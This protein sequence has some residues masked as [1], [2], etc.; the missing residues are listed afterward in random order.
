MN[1]M[2]KVGVLMLLVALVAPQY[3]AGGTFVPTPV[4][5]NPTTQ[6]SH[7]A[8]VTLRLSTATARP[9]ESL[10]LFADYTALGLITTSLIVSP[11]D[12]VRFTPAVPSPCHDQTHDEEC[13]VFPLQA[14]ITG[15]VS[16][17]AVTHGETF[18]ADCQCW[19]FVTVS[20]PVVTLDISGPPNF[21]PPPRA[22]L[23]ML[24]QESSMAPL[25]GWMVF[26]SSRDA[27]YEIHSMRADG[28]SIQR[29]TSNDVHD[30]GADISPDG[31]TIVFQSRRESHNSLYLMNR[32]GTNQRRISPAGGWD[33]DP[34]WSPDGR[35]IAFT[36]YRNGN[37]EI[38]VMQADGSDARRL[39]ITPTNATYDSAPS[40]SPDGQTIAF[41]S[42]RHGGTQPSIYVMAADGTNL[43]RLTEG[44][45][46]YPVWS[47]TSQELAYISFAEATGGGSVYRIR[48]DGTQRTRV[49]T[50]RAVYAEPVW[51]PDGTMLAF[52][53]AGQHA[54]NA[55][56][57]VKA[58]GS[59]ERLILHRDAQN[60]ITDWAP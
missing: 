20:S 54:L 17:R 44:T 8:S 12:A 56:H 21:P 30:L 31:T 53:A 19:R 32:D 1:S 49:T 39:T 42:N 36:S 25:V 2:L 58:D 37:A 5:A 35:Q 15:T 14:L 55:I 16:F 11:T 22:Y 51:S 48:S 18:D 10:T 6:A 47:P 26:S 57:V 40:W 28:S 13:K 24:A 27:I 9:G 33:Q 34:A 50:N 4:L 23:P 59:G 3:V 60:A 38:Y 46:R 7:N 52:T 29:L 45:D 41:H 43:R